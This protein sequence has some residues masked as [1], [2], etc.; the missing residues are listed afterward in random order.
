MG[1]KRLIHRQKSAS[2]GAN[3][4]NIGL[5]LS[6]LDLLYQ[7]ILPVNP[8]SKQVSTLLVMKGGLCVEAV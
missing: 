3:P 7:I 6:G 8:P 2:G 4:E 5:G 1:A